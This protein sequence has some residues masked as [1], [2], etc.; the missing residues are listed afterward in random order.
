MPES[1]IP[2]AYQDAVTDHP[3]IEQWCSTVL[4]G[5]SARLL[6]LGP[7]WSG[8]SH[9]AYAALS[10]LI[11]AGYAS[12]SIT[13]HQAHDLSRTYQPDMVEY[14]TPVTVVDDLTLSVDLAREPGGPRQADTVEVQ[15]MMALEAGALAEAVDRLTARPNRSW[16]L[17]AS[18]AEHLVET[19]GHETAHRILAVAEQAE[20]PPR[21]RPTLPSW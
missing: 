17:I 5:H 6:L 3:A 11:A 1:P 10:R 21:A 2:L 15:A 8:K 14:A 12:E 16:I 18:C 13:V 7:H 4:A 20:L 19:V 9:A